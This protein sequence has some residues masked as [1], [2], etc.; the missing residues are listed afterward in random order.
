MGLLKQLPKS[1]KYTLTNPKFFGLNFTEGEKNAVLIR[2]L[3]VKIRSRL[4][5]LRLVKNIFL[6][7]SIITL[8]C[9]HCVTR[10]RITFENQISITDTMIY[11]RLLNAFWIIL[12]HDDGNLRSYA[13]IEYL[14]VHDPILPKNW[15]FNYFFMIINWVVFC[16]YD[17]CPDPIDCVSRTEILQCKTKNLILNQITGQTTEKML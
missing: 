10:V 7:L 4:A 15:S 12:W 11:P 13:R 1:G 2:K 16:T 8:K 5:N 6:P 14:C 17:F 9:V 3:G